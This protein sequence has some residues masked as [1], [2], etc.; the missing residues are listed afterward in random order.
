QLRARPQPQVGELAIESNA[1][2]R[3]VQ[4]R[5]RV[6]ATPFP[7]GALRGAQTPRQLAEMARATPQEAASLLDGGAV[8]PW[9]QQNGWSC[10]ITV[11]GATGLAALQQYFEALGL[12]PPPRVELRT[13][14]VALQGPA[15]GTTSGQVV[16]GT[17]EKRAVFAHARADQP[18]LS[19]GPVECRG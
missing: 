3:R 1:G 12:T 13:S 18:W 4:V 6:P 9:D 8:A 16:V 11:R 7:D 17:P 5:V 10:P 2:A 14:A 19:V 15:G